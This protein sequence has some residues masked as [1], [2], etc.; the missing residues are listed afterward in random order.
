MA[1]ALLKDVL[2]AN[3]HKQVRCPVCTTWVLLD[4]EEMYGE[5]GRC[6][7]EVIIR[8]P[9]DERKTEPETVAEHNRQ[10]LQE[11]SKIDELQAKLT[12]QTALAAARLEALEKAREY[13]IEWHWPPDM[14]EMP[15]PDED[16]PASGRGVFAWVLRDE[17]YKWYERVY[18]S[19]EDKSFIDDD[20]CGVLNILCWHYPPVFPDKP[21]PGQNDFL[22][23]AKVER[24]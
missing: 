9:G 1:Y 13:S 2:E 14:P 3:G 19:N 23:L 18:Y 15:P 20:D 24:K 5:C 4:N 10:A 17:G 21:Q 22:G 16:G 8:F 12:G 11:R 7:D 6:G